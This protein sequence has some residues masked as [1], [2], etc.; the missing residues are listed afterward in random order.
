MAD[1]LSWLADC[2][3]ER[4]ES[5]SGR[6]TWRCKDLTRRVRSRA[7]GDL[8]AVFDCDDT[9]RDR[10]ELYVY[11]I[12]NG[13]CNVSASIEGMRATDFRERLGWYE[14]R[15]VAMLQVGLSVET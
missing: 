15:I 7:W 1:R 10:V 6:E 13:V 14:S 8:V 11:A 3:Y 5:P 4:A 9:G 2:G 12:D